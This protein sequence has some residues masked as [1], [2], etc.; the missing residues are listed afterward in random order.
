MIMARR[1]RQRE[2]DLSSSVMGAAVRGDP[3]EELPEQP[4]P[5][6]GPEDDD[7]G[8][9]VGSMIRGSDELDEEGDE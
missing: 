9:I 2:P 7:Y 4:P 8:S 5:S 6:R 1:R 3:E